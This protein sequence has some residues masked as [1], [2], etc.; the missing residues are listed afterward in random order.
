MKAHLFDHVPRRQI[1][2]GH[3]HEN[4]V[5]IGSQ[6]LFQRIDAGLTTAFT[7]PVTLAECLVLPAQTGAHEL[8]S[9][10]RQ[11]IAAAPHTRFVAIDDQTAT[12]AARIRAAHRCSLLDAF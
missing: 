9:Q 12:L 5:G 10:F 11:T 7:T 3:V 4:A 1:T 8:V 6:P 2:P